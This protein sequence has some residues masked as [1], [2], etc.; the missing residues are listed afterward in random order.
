MKKNARFHDSQGGT[1]LA[2]HVI[3][4][5][6]RNEIIEIA[7]DGSIKMR[8]KSPADHKKL[9]KNLVIYLAEVLDVGQQEVEVVA[10][11]TGR[12]KLVSIIGLSAKT[13]HNRILKNLS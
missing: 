11:I 1:A 2:V 3:P 9:N 4:R 8:L 7:R 12:S 6:A 13:A 10:G 5:A